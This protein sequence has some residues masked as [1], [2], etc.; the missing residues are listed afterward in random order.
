MDPG[1]VFTR[2]RKKKMFSHRKI[3]HARC[4]EFT[5]KGYFEFFFLQDCV[6]EDCSEVKLWLDTYLFEK[7]PFPQSPEDYLSWISKN[8][9]FVSKRNARISS[10][11]LNV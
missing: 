8:L 2:I 10:F 7:D 3:I 9:D 1:P 5:F 6:S 11:L 4:A